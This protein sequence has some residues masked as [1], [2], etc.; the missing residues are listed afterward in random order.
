VGSE[1]LG[2]VA[3]A[4]LV[5]LQLLAAVWVYQD[6]ARRSRTAW[7]WGFA[8]AAAGPVSFP[9]YVLLA[10]PPE[11]DWGAAELLA[12]A[13]LGLVAAPLLASLA[14]GSWVGLGAVAGVVV[15]QSGAL[16]AGCWQVLRR[17]GLSWRSVGL[18][19]QGSLRWAGLGLLAGIPLVAAVHY[20]VQP[21]AVY[22]LGLVIG[23]DRARA[24]AELEQYS[25]PLVQAIPP[26]R[27][28]PAVALFAV[29][30]CG[31]VPLA[32]EVFFRGLVYRAARHRLPWGWA[33]VLTGLLF[34]GVHLQVAN[35]LPI[36]VLGWAFAAAVERT[37]S[38]VP[39]VAMHG[40]NNLVALVVT[41]TQR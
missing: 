14:L 37:G 41:Y 29:L 9:A 23:H 16:L 31:L 13:V 21:A 8:V 25:N 2:V 22:L 38:L 36:A 18:G 30:V 26:L 27:D 10:R 33:A 28:W 6:A 35:F 3:R 11:E 20:A 4:G 34:A 12:V 40:V 15:A 5:A 1:V 39:A 7:W 24:L 19:R 32:E 17:R